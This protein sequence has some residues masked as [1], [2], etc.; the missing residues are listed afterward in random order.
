MCYWHQIDRRQN[1]SLYHWLRLFSATDFDD[2]FVWSVQK[3]TLYEP[4]YKERKSTD[5]YVRQIPGSEVQ[6]FF[7][8]SS[9]ARFVWVC[10][11][12]IHMRYWP[13]VRSRWLDMGRVLLMRFH[14]TKSIKRTRSI[15]SHLDQIS[16]VKR[17]HIF[18]DRSKVFIS[19]FCFHLF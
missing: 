16:L 17:E 1:I 11:K 12:Y 6:W 15:F 13:S 18:H 9:L 5:P 14:G 2:I 19:F 8:L 4:N 10:M 7:V 3:L